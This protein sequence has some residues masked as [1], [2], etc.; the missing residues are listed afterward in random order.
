MDGRRCV[1]IDKR[2]DVGKKALGSEMHTLD[3]IKEEWQPGP[4]SDQQTL[5]RLLK[6]VKAATRAKCGHEETC[7]IIINAVLLVK[8]KVF[9][10]TVTH[11]QIKTSTTDKGAASSFTHL[12]L[13]SLLNAENLKCTLQALGN[14]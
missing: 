5:D 4:V 14:R 12:N 8:K 11:K 7:T 1:R 3:F 2:T 9:D 10:G 13:C 6:Y